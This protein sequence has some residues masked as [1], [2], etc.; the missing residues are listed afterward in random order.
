MEGL[1]QKKKKELVM[2]N[3]YF[4]DMEVFSTKKKQSKSKE[5]CG[6]Q[7]FIPFPES[8]ASCEDN[9]V[10][11]AWNLWFHFVEIMRKKINNWRRRKKRKDR[12][13]YTKTAPNEILATFSHSSENEVLTVTIQSWVAEILNLPAIKTYPCPPCYP[14]GVY[15][16]IVLKI[17]GDKNPIT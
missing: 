10:L 4:T 13:N 14:L 9:E 17:N 8:L 1:R 7:G 16:E 5:N 15:T 2:E 6:R 3:F 12:K 11:F